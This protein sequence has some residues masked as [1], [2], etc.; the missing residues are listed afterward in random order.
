MNWWSI[1]KNQIASTKGKTFQ[2]DFNQPMIEEE[3][4]DCKKRFQAVQNKLR[5]LT[6]AGL[7]R[8]KEDIYPNFEYYSHKPEES[9]SMSLPQAEVFLSLKGRFPDE[10]YCK[11][12]EQ[13]ENTPTGGSKLENYGEY[14]VLTDNRTVATRKS[15]EEGDNFDFNNYEISIY[16]TEKQQIRSGPPV[17]IFVRHRI[18]YNG[19]YGDEGKTNPELDDKIERIIK[20]ALVF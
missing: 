4:E 16:L 6:I 18:F 19:R 20:G 17:S 7:K 14:R 3:E 1:I 5:N 9:E 13:Y 12:I 11:A 8:K 2:L 15:S 10:I